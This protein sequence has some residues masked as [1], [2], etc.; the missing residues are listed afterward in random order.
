MMPATTP[1]KGIYQLSSS[2]QIYKASASFSAGTVAENEAAADITAETT[3]HIVSDDGQPLRTYAMD[4][5][6][7]G[8]VLPGLP[9]ELIFPDDARFIPLDAGFRW[10]GMSRMHVL[11]AWLEQHWL[12]VAGAALLVPLFVWLMVSRV[13]PAS[14]DI[15]A[16]LLPPVVAQELGEQTMILLDKTYMQPSSIS[17]QQQQE[18]RRRW[19]QLLTQLSLPA[20]TFTLQFRDWDH[21]ANA[22]ALAN[23]HIILTDDIVE[24][25]A[26]HPHELDAVMLHEIGH[27]EHKHSLKVLAEATAMSIMFA[28]M[29]GDIEGAGEMI[30]GA[31]T[32]LVQSAFS[33][34]M[35][36]EAD[37][38]AFTSLQQLHRS[39]EDFAN[40]LRLLT[41]QQQRSQQ[42]CQGENDQEKDIFDYLNSHPDSGER[43]RAAENWRGG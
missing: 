35:E 33:R 34:D 26:D 22:M 27:V 3:V 17:A 8:D 1:V 30:L 9:V 12:A 32:S 5:V 16:E 7:Y 43:I 28:M 15:A 29:F 24:L 40:A 4:T 31:G 13:I 10:P 37:E 2:S 23:G 39:P 11:P 14:A 18:I 25:M 36:R 41:A 19:Q 6:C 42:E 20:D 38:F 21:G